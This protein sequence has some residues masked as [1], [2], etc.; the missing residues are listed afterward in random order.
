M[1]GWIFLLL[2][3]IFL[4]YVTVHLYQRIKKI[5]FYKWWWFFVWFNL[6]QHHKKKLQI[7][8]NM[9]WIKINRIQ[10]YESNFCSSR[11]VKWNCYL[12]NKAVRY[13]WIFVNHWWCNK[14]CCCYSTHL[15]NGKFSILSK[16][17]ITKCNETCRKLN[18]H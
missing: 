7:I 12:K 17:K 9:R 6:N 2:K 4:Y 16:L 10:I 3:K 11:S 15:K 13:N 14:H 1:L 18:W 8:H 5:N